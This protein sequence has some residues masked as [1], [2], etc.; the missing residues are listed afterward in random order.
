MKNIKHEHFL[1]IL[2]AVFLIGGGIGFFAGKGITNKNLQNPQSG[3]ANRGGQ[4]G[5]MGGGNRGGQGSGMMRGSGFASGEVSSVDTN[6]IVVRMRDGSSKIVLYA[7]STE[8]GKFTTG[9]LSDVVVGKQIMVNGT[10]NSDGSVT[11]TNIQIR[12]NMPI[13]KPAKQ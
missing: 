12:P 7:P 10:A 9:V 2:I 13:G 4:G 6:S 5:M 1:I 11:A 8:I 3:F